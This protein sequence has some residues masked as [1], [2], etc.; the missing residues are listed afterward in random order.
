MATFSNYSY[1]NSR[2]YKDVDAK[3]AH[4]IVAILKAEAFATWAMLSPDAGLT[5]RSL[6]KRE[7]NPIN[8]GYAGTPHIPQDAKPEL[9]EGY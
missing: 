9:H 2:L 6:T 1:S 3:L 5:F 7:I 4:H 8:Q